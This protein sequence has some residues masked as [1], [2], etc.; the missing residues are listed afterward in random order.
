LSATF[1]VAIVCR[2]H[3]QQMQNCRVRRILPEMPAVTIARHRDPTDPKRN[4]PRHAETCGGLALFTKW[5][6]LGLLEDLD[7]PPA[8]G[9]RQRTGLH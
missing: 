8:L 4:N 3:R 5:L 7:E 9:G 1:T 2:N 6:L